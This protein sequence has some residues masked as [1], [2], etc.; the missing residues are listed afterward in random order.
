[1]RADTIVPG[2]A[3]SEQSRPNDGMAN[4][5][6]AGKAVVRRIAE[7]DAV[8]CPCGTARRVF[9]RA[10]GGPVGIHH[11]TISEDAQLHYHKRTTEYYVVLEGHGE[12]ELDD[13]R[14]KVGPGDVVYIPP[15]TRHA[16]RGTLTI[17]NVVHPPLDPA[18][19]FVEE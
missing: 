19:E 17:I 18:D 4:E 12:I 14:V 5:G 10:D 2:A 13:E 3:M 11:V 16:A 7:V 9:S 8:D 1:M 6:T 15:L